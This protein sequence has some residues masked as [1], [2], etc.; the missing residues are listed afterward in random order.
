M[1]MQ[2]RMVGSLCWIAASAAGFL[3]LTM[4]HLFAGVSLPVLFGVSTVSM[5]VFWNALIALF[6]AALYLIGVGIATTD[7]AFWDRLLYASASI[8][9]AVMAFTTSLLT[10]PGGVFGTLSL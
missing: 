5:Q 4:L 3:V 6:P 9:M 1:A 7:M 8:G 2:K 10:I